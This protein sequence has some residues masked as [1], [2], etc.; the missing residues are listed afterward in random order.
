MKKV[1]LAS[2]LMVSLSACGS[3]DPFPY[4][5]EARAKLAA[6]ASDVELNVLLGNSSHLPEENLSGMINAQIEIYEKAGYSFEETVIEFKEAVIDASDDERAEFLFRSRVSFNQMKNDLL[7]FHRQA[8]KIDVDL[9]DYMSDDAADAI[10]A[11][12]T[13]VDWYNFGK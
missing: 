2:F 13:E 6:A 10:V 11:L 12:A 5:D 8:E 4:T 1:F 7:H 3:S 9:S